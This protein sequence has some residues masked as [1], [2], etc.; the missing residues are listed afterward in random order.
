[1]CRKQA[2]ALSPFSQ[3]RTEGECK[4]ASCLLHVRA[5]SASLKLNTNGDRPGG[6]RR[7]V[8]RKCDPRNLMFEV[9]MPVISL[10]IHELGIILI[11][12]VTEPLLVQSFMAFKLTVY[13]P[14]IT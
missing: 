2:R 6:F 1:M 11:R 3:I 13:Y 9:I 8:S 7:E 14:E 5:S 4:A 10:I 12:L